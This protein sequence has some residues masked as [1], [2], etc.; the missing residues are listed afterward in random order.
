MQLGFHHDIRRCIGCRACLMACRSIHGLERGM[1][2]REVYSYRAEPGRFYLSVACNHCENPECV[3]V[4]LAGAYTKRPDGVVIQDPAKCTGC[5]LCTLT[6]PH[7]VP[8]Y[9]VTR[10]KVTKCDFCADR[11][12]AG[13]P[14]AC[15][16]ACPT[17]A[18][19]VIDLTTFDQPGALA[20]VPGFP[21][22]PL[23]TPSVRF[24]LPPNPPEKEGGV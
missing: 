14:P 22:S 2:W 18:L 1:K 16:A 17:S 3:R 8:R 20:S 10:R 13:M 9:S 11:L 21:D 4:C 5:R 19:S 15:I 12:A 23:T 24:T 6:C 7:G